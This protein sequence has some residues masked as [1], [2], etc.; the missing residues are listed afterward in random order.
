MTASETGKFLRMVRNAAKGK[1]E[2]RGHKVTLRTEGLLWKEHGC[3]RTFVVKAYWPDPLVVRLY[4]DHYSIRYPR[5]QEIA[6]PTRPKAEITIAPSEAANA[7]VL[8]WA[9][10]YDPR[11]VSAF[12]PLPFEVEAKA[13]P[14]WLY[15]WSKKARQIYDDRFS[16]PDPTVEVARAVL[17]LKDAP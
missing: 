12:G 3:T 15:A 2:A 6:Y 8:D 17:G 16:R 9:L 14:S 1:L 13:N 7:D 11:V 5:R 10:T 4:V